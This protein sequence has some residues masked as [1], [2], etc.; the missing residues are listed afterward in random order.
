MDLFKAMGLSALLTLC[1]A[2]VIGSQGTSGGSLAIYA[3]NID[4]L[5]FFWSWPVFICGSGLGWGI[6]L[7]Q[8]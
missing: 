3:I 5:R 1:I 8:R 6:M 4:G 2:L 7:L